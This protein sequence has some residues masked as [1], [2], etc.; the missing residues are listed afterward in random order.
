MKL[1]ILI[2]FACGAGTWSAEQSRI[3]VKTELLV[4][5]KSLGKPHLRV[6]ANEEGEMTVGTREKNR[7]RMKVLARPIDGKLDEM[8]L[9]MDLEYN[10]GER[11]IRSKPQVIAKAG[12]EAIMTLEESTTKGEKIQLKVLAK[13]VVR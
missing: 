13:P 10:S 6:I 1:A 11:Q 7:M 12:S 8:L 5:G 9:D 2:L 4:N 3:D